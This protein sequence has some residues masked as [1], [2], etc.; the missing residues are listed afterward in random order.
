MYPSRRSTDL[1]N[2]CGITTVGAAYCWGDNNRGQLGDGTTTGSTTPEGVGGG[3]TFATVRTGA[4]HTCG[5]A[6]APT[7]NTADCCGDN[8]PGQLG[9]AATAT[10][11]SLITRA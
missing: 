8:L 9:T 5:I 11:A 2:T 7:M 3:L 10:G 4:G 1:L 6:T